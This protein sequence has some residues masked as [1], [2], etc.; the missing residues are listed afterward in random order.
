MSSPP[1]RLKSDGKTSPNHEDHAVDGR[2]GEERKERG[3][4]SVVHNTN[5][6]VSLRQTHQTGWAG[7]NERTVCL[8]TKHI[9]RS[10][11][12][13]TS[14]RS[15]GFV[16]RRRRVFGLFPHARTPAVLFVVYAAC[17]F[18]G[19]FHDPRLLQDN[20]RRVRTAAWHTSTLDSPL[21]SIDNRF[22]RSGPEWGRWELACDLVGF[23]GSRLRSI[24]RVQ[25]RRESGVAV[26]RP[27]GEEK[28]I[29]SRSTQYGRA[30]LTANRSPQE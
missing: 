7:R 5:T 9:Y 19:H 3:A 14:S 4:S 2:G 16:G 8:V 29:G 27:R 1:R 15:G 11:D 20:R 24:F 12:L 18:S 23:G 21:L 28:Y 30:R 10:L 26:T 22:F 25:L 6:Q 17:D 13:R